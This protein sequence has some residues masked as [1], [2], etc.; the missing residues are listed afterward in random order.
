MLR[1]TTMG[2]S[3]CCCPGWTG[4]NG[5]VKWKKPSVQTGAANCRY[6]L[7]VLSCQHLGKLQL[8][9]L[10]FCLVWSSVPVWSLLR[11]RCLWKLWCVTTQ[12]AACSESST[13][14]LGS[15]RLF[16]QDTTQED[17]ETG[18]GACHSPKI[19]A[20]TT[21]NENCKT[22]QRGFTWPGNKGDSNKNTK[23]FSFI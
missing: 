1:L 10:L 16:L 8:R 11:Y 22:P 5:W 13:W 3:V 6:W 9:G 2:T 20:L 12:L 17:L 19:M 18:L 23:N 7:A 21:N 15:I 4:E 14:P